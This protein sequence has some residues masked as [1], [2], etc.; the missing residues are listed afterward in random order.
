MYN[1]G[2][3]IQGLLATALIYLL[4]QNASLFLLLCQPKKNLALANPS[5]SGNNSN[6]RQRAGEL[7]SN[8]MQGAKESE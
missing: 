7:K 6:E 5:R 8:A 1:E 2:K 3:I 4:V